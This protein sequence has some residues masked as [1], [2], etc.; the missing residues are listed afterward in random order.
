MSLAECQ[1]DTILRK[2]TFIMNRFTNMIVKSIGLGSEIKKSSPLDGENK[3]KPTFKDPSGLPKGKAYL[4]LVI[5]NCS[6]SRSRSLISANLSFSWTM[7]L[8][9]PSGLEV[10]L[11]EFINSLIR[12][13]HGRQS[14]A[15]ACVTLCCLNLQ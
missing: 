5:W 6:S 2:H 9:T 7:M 12:L 8:P 13:F 1:N 11:V 15:I 14:L 4:K 3:M 10:Q